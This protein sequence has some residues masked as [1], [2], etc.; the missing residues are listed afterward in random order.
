MKKL[1]FLLIP[2]VF[3][4]CK[5]EPRAVNFIAMDTFMTVMVYAP[6]MSQ[7]ITGY[8]L[9]GCHSQIAVLD[10]SLSVTKPLSDVY[11][12]NHSDGEAV[13]VKKETLE[14]IEYSLLMHKKTD[15]AFNPSLYPVIKEWGFT[16]K[17]YKIP[18]DD[19]IKKLL[20]YT[21]FT[22]IKTSDK[23]SCQIQIPKNM[24]LDFGAIGKGY[25]GDLAL[26][27]LKKNGIE[28]ALLDFGGNVQTLG[29]KPDGKP[30][31]IGIKKPWTDEIACS[32][33]VESKAVITSGG[34]ERYFTGDDGK[35]YIHIFDPKTGK[36]AESDLESV[37]IIAPNGTYAD[38][39][40]TS[41]FVMG[42]EKAISF[43]KNNPDFD[44][45]FIT[46]DDELIYS[47]GLK[48][49]INLVLDFPKVSVISL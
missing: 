48:N 6:S 7:E 46:K 42:K 47:Q 43:W 25:A 38:A 2:L 44:F 32:I 8:L 15:G 21:D 40:S 5:P 45:V 36:P 27:Y 3:L 23:D 16:T 20:T 30:W 28:S 31:T 10:N 35:K 11:K 22:L 17:N 24:Q 39:L 37:T 49:S 33:E 34:Y 26:N 1:F 14:L 4:S 19:K 29:T 18:E 41:L 9:D 12:L 13:K